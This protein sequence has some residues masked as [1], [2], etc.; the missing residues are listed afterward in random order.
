MGYFDLHFFTF[1]FT[2]KCADMSPVWCPDDGKPSNL[3]ADL[4]RLCY[5]IDN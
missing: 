4:A 3:A 2:L 1:V 5:C